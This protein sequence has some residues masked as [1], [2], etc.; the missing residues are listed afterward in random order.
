[1]TNTDLLCGDGLGHVGDD[2]AEESVVRGEAD[3]QLKLVVLA[4][5]VAG[6]L[7]TGYQLRVHPA[8]K[9]IRTV[10]EVSLTLLSML[11]SCCTSVLLS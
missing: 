4:Q 8:K 7:D 9:S 3:E 10:I 2:P 11:F 6:R 1:M 5:P